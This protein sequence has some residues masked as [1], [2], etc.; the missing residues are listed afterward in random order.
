[1]TILLLV[2]AGYVLGSIPWGYWLPRLFAGVDMTGEQWAQLATASAIWILLPFVA[3]LV[4]VT[5]AEV[6]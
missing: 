2:L 1:M 6:K 5:R 4:R 3:G